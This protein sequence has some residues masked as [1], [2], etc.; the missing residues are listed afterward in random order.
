M[1]KT[2]KTR[3][4][5]PITVIKS[6]INPLSNDLKGKLSTAFQEVVSKIK[7]KHLS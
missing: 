4:N 2:P 5:R 1:S 6:V 3:I 7:D